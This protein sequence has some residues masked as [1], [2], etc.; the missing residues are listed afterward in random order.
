MVH[1]LFAIVLLAATPAT[2]L[3]QQRQWQFGGKVGPAFTNLAL[4][5]DDGQT[6]HARIAALGGGFFVL[7]ITPR[8]AVQFE[9]MS[10]PKGVRLEEPGTG[11]AQTLMLR[12]F[13]MPV[14]ARVNGPKVGSGILYGLAGPFFGIRT[15]AKAQ[16]S[17]VINSVGTGVR[18]EAGDAIERFESGLIVGGG[19]E[20]GAHLLVEGRYSHGLTNVNRV[21]GANPFT[22]RGISFTTGVRF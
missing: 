20:L 1:R 14:L 2:A 5:S 16:R 9:A 15:S 6:Y 10:S 12:Y 22:N 8:L 11:Y 21:D 17:T 13:E 18:E 4:A 19:L 7:P 3:A